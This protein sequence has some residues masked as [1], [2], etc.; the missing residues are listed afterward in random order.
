MESDYYFKLIESDNPVFVFVG[1]MS[2]EKK[3]FCGL[4]VGDKINRIGDLNRSG[5]AALN[6][7]QRFKTYV[8]YAGIFHL[9]KF[10]LDGAPADIL[11]FEMRENERPEGIN[12]PCYCGYIIIE[13]E[14]FK[15]LLVPD[16]KNNNPVYILRPKFGIVL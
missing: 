2:I 10:Y 14:D 5:Q 15:E 6:R 16:L 9:E 3:E 8:T 12:E 1:Q 4:K 7:M 13:Q 11:M